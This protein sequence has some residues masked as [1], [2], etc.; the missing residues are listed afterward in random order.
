MRVERLDLLAYGHLRDVVLDLAAPARGLTIVEGPNEAGKSTA[1]RAFFALLF[2]IPRA[3]RDDHVHGRAGLRVGAVLS[4]DGGT[5]LELVR[6]GLGSAPVVGADGARVDPGTVDRL[7]GP[8]DEQTYRRLFVL[9]HEALRA[10]SEELLESGGELGRLLFGA[11]L[12]DGS[13]S[14]ALSSLEERSRALFRP[15]GTTQPLARSLAAYRTTMAAAR[16]ARVRSRVWEEMSVAAGEAEERV[17]RAEAAARDARSERDRLERVRVARPLVAQRDAATQASERARAEGVVGS[18]DWVTRASALRDEVSS[19]G[20]ERIRSLG[21]VQRLSEAVASHEVQAGLLEH[22]REVDALVRGV[23]RYDKDAADLDKR[24]GALSKAEEQLAETLSAL[25][26][27]VDDGRVVGDASLAQVED[28]ARRRGEESARR[29]KAEEELARV[30]A[31]VAA[32]ELL[33]ETLPGAVDVGEVARALAIVRPT[34]ES[35][36]SLAAMLASRARREQE[37][38]SAAARLGLGGRSVGEIESLALPAASVIS[39]EQARRESLRTELDEV[40]RRESE[41]DEETSALADAIARLGGASGL[42]EPSRLARARAHRDAGWR[43]VR[44]ALGGAPTDE[45][46]WAREVPL[47][48]AFSRA[49]SDADDAADE[50]F[51]H[52]DDLAKLA[53]LEARDERVREQREALGSRRD[54]IARESAERDGAWEGLWSSVGVAAGDP[55]RMGD[56]RD[57]AGALLAD[58]AALR[59]AE[60]AVAAVR[61]SVAEHHRVLRVA[62]A[63]LGAQPSGERLEELVPLAEELVAAEAARD[64]ERRA[65]SGSLRRSR[66]ERAARERALGE[67]ARGVAAWEQEWGRA[68]GVLRLPAEIS[69]GAALAAARAYRVLPAHRREVDG[70]RARVAGI[71]RDLAAFESN[72]R[73]VEEATIGASGLPVLEVVDALARALASGRLAFDARSAL[74]GERVQAELALAKAESELAGA[75]DALSRAREEVGATGDVPVDPVIERSKTVSDALERIASA[76]ESLVAQGAGRTL[77]EVL[78]EVGGVGLDGDALDDAI[79][80]LD[81]LLGRAEQERTEAGT[82]LGE[83]RARLTAVTGSETASDLEQDAQGELAL[84]AGFA[85]EYARVAVA[86]A[87][88]RAVLAEYGERHKGPM[89]ERAGEVFSSL[90]N[91]AFD[92][93]VPDLHGERQVLLARRR[94]GELLEAVQLSDGTRDQLYLALRLAGIEHHLAR[95]EQ[96]VP[97]VLDDLLVNF[98]DERSESALAALADLGAGTQVVL[99]THHASLG[100]AARRA[101]GPDRVSV[102]SMPARSHDLPRP[103]APPTSARAGGGRPRRRGDGAAGESVVEAIRSEGRALA[104]QEIL[105]RTGLDDSSWS[106]VV[107][108][109]VSSGA[110]RQEGSRRGARYRLPDTAGG[111]KVPISSSPGPAETIVMS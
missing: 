94:N 82:A 109:L 32:A 91:G 73:A 51:A 20:R 29:T 72:V 14:A 52:A 93:L 106:R 22:A 47:A 103:S 35:E 76:E 38:A 36:R 95:L 41:L 108:E 87:V 101:L 54:E 50:R 86:A 53:V 33:L 69:P 23:D 34:V 10:G 81:A 63:D 2:G 77:A 31:D 45:T 58:I 96:P 107:R 100:A 27:P 15:Q 102:V 67:A 78:A 40:R 13:V 89:L 57:R 21:E 12:G 79:S 99:F 48:E 83:A 85:D 59:D 71:E 46:G 30:D 90:T 7:L 6:Q 97:V 37:V 26:M 49:L 11:T 44:D 1:M 92:A 64:E 39:A 25:G 8:V 5:R 56:W 111:P 28:L 84:V 105:E 104:K 3:A 60:E 19:A 98:D 88:L 74:A 18:S 70:L 43:V 17:R 66:E 4:A 24:K 16:Q 68:V 75:S 9:D 110:I 55:A 80:E 42:P 62:L 65:A 61:T